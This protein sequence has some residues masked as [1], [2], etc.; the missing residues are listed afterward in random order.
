MWKVLGGVCGAGLFVALSLTVDVR[1][2]AATAIIEQHDDALPAAV[3]CEEQSA[4]VGKGDWIFGSRRDPVTDIYA[5][6]GDPAQSCHHP[7]VRAAAG[8]DRPGG[9]CYLLRRIGTGD[10]DLQ[11]SCTERHD[12]FSDGDVTALQCS[13]WETRV[14][15]MVDG[16][17]SMT[18]A[19]DVDSVRQSRGVCNAM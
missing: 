6:V 17:F 11:M 15:A 4:S 7:D 13:G 9:S 18:I 19:G 1:Q 10:A 5:L 8:Y 14:T 3:V 12:P 16:G 2:S